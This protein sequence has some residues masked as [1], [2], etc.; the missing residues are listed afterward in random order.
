MKT[1]ADKMKQQSP[2]KKKTNPEKHIHNIPGLGEVDD[3]GLTLLKKRDPK[4]YEK[5][6]NWN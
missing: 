6:M 2:E 5:M 3:I 4:A 1:Q